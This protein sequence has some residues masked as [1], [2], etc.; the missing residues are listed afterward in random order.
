MKKKMP[1][2]RL[3]PNSSASPFVVV[4]VACF[5]AL[6]GMPMSHAQFPL[7]DTSPDALTKAFAKLDITDEPQVVDHTCIES[8][9]YP[10]ERC[11]YTYV[12]ECATV[13]SPLV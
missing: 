13:D 11:F 1:L 3:I 8:T 7:C 12:P 10:G 6:L 4:S 9:G 2:S 5:V